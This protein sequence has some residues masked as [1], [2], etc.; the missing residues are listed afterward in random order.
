MNVSVFLPNKI[1]FTI[2][3]PK[4]LQFETNC[5]DSAYT[6]LKIQQAAGL[7]PADYIKSFL[8]IALLFNFGYRN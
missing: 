2:M 8:Q 7:Y 5:I 6:L 4:R 1:D 3:G